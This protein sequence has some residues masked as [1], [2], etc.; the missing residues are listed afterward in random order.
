MTEPTNQ[1]QLELWLKDRPP[2]FAVAIAARVA[3]RAVPYLVETLC[4]DPSRRRT[5]FLLPALCALAG[6]SFAARWPQRASETRKV[7]RRIARELGDAFAEVD[8][9]IRISIIEYNEIYAPPP[10]ELV[11]D[12]KAFPLSEG[13]I[14]AIT[15]AVQAVTDCMDLEKGLANRSAPAEAAIRCFRVACRNR[16]NGGGATYLELLTGEDED[17]AEFDAESVD[18]ALA[19]ARRLESALAKEQV[20]Q[21]AARHL[22]A[23]PL[24]QGS[25]PLWA[26]RRWADLKDELPDDEQWWVWT[27]WYEAHLSATHLNE[28][29]ELVRATIG[30]HLAD[31][32]VAVNTTLAKTIETHTDP[33][34]LAVEQAHREV[35]SAAGTFNFNAHI[36]RVQRSLSEDPAEVVGAAKDMLESVMKTILDRR[37]K[38][39]PAKIK[40]PTLTNLCLAELQLQPN[41]EPATPADR[42]A[43]KFA[44]SAGSMMEAINNLRNN[45]GTGHGR[46]DSKDNAQASELSIP[47]A[48]LAA[49]ISLTLSAWLL[50]HDDS[51]SSVH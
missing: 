26:G 32:V 19:D 16:S 18:A 35:D 8:S 31:G 43:R 34:A 24:W 28:T 23:T 44:S 30:E 21:H 7:A 40:F 1:H 13:A 22:S 17:D 48:R 2:E 10:S 14:L 9:G 20:A 38:S 12:A 39:V 6:V 15:Y 51:Q 3:M 29:V 36:R 47:D 5:E 46:A 11:L 42:H 4:S 25:P 41:S 27:D 49:A 45:V 50:H 37:G 33:L